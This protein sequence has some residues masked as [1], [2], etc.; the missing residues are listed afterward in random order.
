MVHSKYFELQILEQTQD[1][2]LVHYKGWPRKY[3]EWR[4]FSDILDISNSSIEP[5]AKELFKKQLHL[6]IAKQIQWRK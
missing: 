3:D 6:Q 1:S 2:A 4:H 5:N